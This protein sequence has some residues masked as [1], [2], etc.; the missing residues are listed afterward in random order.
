[1]TTDD[2]K[3]I[4]GLIETRC[5][6]LNGDACR[7]WLLVMLNHVGELNKMVLAQAERIAAQSALL[8]NKSE[9]G[10]LA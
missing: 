4:R 3:A 9:V 8:T 6:W 1:M 10:K 5:V 2:E 7:A